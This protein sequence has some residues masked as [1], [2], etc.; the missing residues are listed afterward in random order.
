MQG[1]RQQQN[2][3]VWECNHE[4]LQIEPW[5][6]DSLR[7]RSTISAGIR[8]DLLSV[9]LP[10]AETHAQIT[11]GAGGATIRN[12]AISAS[13]SPEGCISFSNTASET[14]LLAEEPP[15]RA[16]RLPPRAFKAV[17]S[18][19]FHLEARFRAYDDEHLYGLGQHQHGRLNQKG[20]TIDL[21]QRNT[22][23]SIPFLFSSRGY[24]LLWHNPG[25]GRVELGNNTRVGC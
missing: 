4:I 2:T 1:F 5:G 15:V 24:G 22:E 6:R 25:V 7:V 3:L 8:D 13:V 16:T 18:D 12:G 14:A 11:I 10:P 17:H 9:L 19:L 21:I 23:V 20:C